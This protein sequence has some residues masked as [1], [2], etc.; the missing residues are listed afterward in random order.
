ML[1]LILFLSLRRKLM[2][3]TL[4]HFQ[5]TDYLAMK[6]RRKEEITENNHGPCRLLR[7]TVDAFWGGTSISGIS[8]AGNKDNHSFRRTCWMIIFLVFTCLTFYGLW[9]VINEYMK[10]PV[11]ASIKVENNEKV[12]F[13]I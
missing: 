8:N 6:I 12:S 13:S 9:E 10:Y 5:Q 1:C 2:L 3:V 11:I 4:F 7:Q